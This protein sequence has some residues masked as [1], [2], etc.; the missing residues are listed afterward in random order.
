MRAPELPL[1]D[2][3]PG[4]RLDALLRTLRPSDPGATGALVTLVALAEHPDAEVR[5]TLVQRLPL[6]AHGPAGPAPE[7]VDA[8]AHRC[9]DADVR[10]R[11]AACF[12]LGTLWRDLD[13]PAVRDALAA[14]L[15]DDDV[16]V[17]DEALL[18]LAHRADP[19]ALPAVRDALAQPAGAVSRLVL[20]AAG[21]L[22]DVDLHDLVRA[23]AGDGSGWDEDDLD[24][25]EAV[26][27]LTDPT[28]LGDDLLD[29]VADLC[30]AAAHGRPPGR[31]V[32]AW[33]ALDGV[34]D[35]APHRAGQAMAEVAAR[36]ADDP[37]ALAHLRQRSALGALA[38]AAAR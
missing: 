15:G 31:S 18:G 28:G 30:R 6:M 26:V 17:R 36:L 35:V 34:L 22:G 37:A 25:L 29:G 4:R 38:G 32:A 16:E 10:V 33:E 11:E 21:A 1:A 24:V 9:A 7:L 14:R 12:A 20:E 19:R 5:A 8:V 27:R 13:R 23:H 2:V 3:V